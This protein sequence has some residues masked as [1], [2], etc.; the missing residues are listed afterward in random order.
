MFCVILANAGI[1]VN[2][3]FQTGF[4]S[5]FILVNTGAGMT[6]LCDDYTVGHLSTI[7]ILLFEK[8]IKDQ[9]SSVTNGING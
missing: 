7:K 8:G 3:N 4:W 2:S 6:N 9:S 5:E 1:H